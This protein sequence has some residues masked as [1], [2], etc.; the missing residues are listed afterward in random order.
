LIPL[1]AMVDA[2]K[3]FLKKQKRSA[4]LSQKELIRIA[5]RTMGLDE[6]AP[7]KAEERIIEYMVNKNSDHKLANMS[8][9][10]FADETASE[11]P[12]P[13]GGA[14]SAY[15]G[16]LGAALA[17]MVANLSSHKKGWDDRWDEF[18]SWAE[19]GEW[20]KAKL[21]SSVDADT[22]AFNGIMKAMALPN[23]S[24]EE[25]STRKKAI[26]DATRIAIDIPFSVMQTAYASMEVIRVMAMT[27]NPNSI[28]DAG[29]AA[30]C[31][32]TAVMGAFLNIQINAAMFEDKIF[33]ADVVAKGKMIEE[34][35]M[36]EENEILAIVNKK[37]G[38]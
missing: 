13:G 14:I 37:I 25:K 12:A 24:V 33:A 10:D 31:A 5:V 8:L 21:I 29:V 27:G 17:T 11:S 9:A 15:A 28:S 20:Y 6:V 19:K 7:F 34:K 23:S 26:E 32:R 16:A 36:L 22:R 3:Y 2:G 18:S 35:A 1:K 4:G 30:L 38:S